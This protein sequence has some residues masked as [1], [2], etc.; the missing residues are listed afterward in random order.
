MKFE[1]YVKAGYPCLWV[2]THEEKRAIKNLSKE[3]NGNYTIYK[4]DIISGLKNI[5]TEKIENLPD[6]TE[7]LKAISSFPEKSIIFLCDFHRFLTGIE[8]ARLLRN[9]ISACKSVRK[10]I[11]IISPNSGPIPSE[12]EKEI[13]LFPFDL[14]NVEELK[15]LA[16]QIIED[17]NMS[18]EITDNIISGAKGLTMEEAENAFSLSLITEKKLSREI[19]ENEKLQIVKK[20]GL[21][22]IYNPIP[23]DQ[24]GGLEEIISYVEKRIPSFSNPELPAIKPLLLIGPPGTGKTLTAKVCASILGLPLIRLDLGALKGGLVGLSEENLRKAEKTIDAISP[25]VVLM[26]EIDKSLSGSQ[27][28][29]K[30]DGGTSSNMIGELLNWME[31]SKVRKLIIGTCNNIENLLEISQGAFLRRFGAVFLVDFPSENERKQILSIMNK[32]YKTTIPESYIS[33]MNQWTGAEIEKFC[34]DSVYDGTE[35]AFI[36]IKPL[37]LQNKEIIEKAREW[38]KWNARSANSIS[39]KQEEKQTRKLNI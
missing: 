36:N 17:N 38:A 22:E 39:S 21:M 3:A 7:V 31:E 12:L 34:I 8:V 19:L 35:E 29:G 30:T 16:K 25:C 27:S 9:Q 26:D 37:A 32:K 33:K 23:V 24:L 5:N 20:S 11:V 1:N 13:I 2:Q 4:W 14:P 18:T 28:S 6:P 15:G 10:H